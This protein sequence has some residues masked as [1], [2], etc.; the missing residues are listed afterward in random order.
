MGERLSAIHQALRGMIERYRPVEAAVETLYFAR[1]VSSA[2]PVAQARGVLLLALHQFGVE[3]YEYSPQAVKLAIVGR[4][5]AEKHQVQELVRVLLGL[6]ALPSSDHAADALALAICHLQSSAG[7][8]RIRA[9]L[10]RA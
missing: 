4:G 10:A 2:M 7:M 8:R 6:E 5:R 9:G 1:N 3:A